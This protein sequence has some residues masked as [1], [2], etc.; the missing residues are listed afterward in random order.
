LIRQFVPSYQGLNDQA[1]RFS[2]E[3]AAEIL[4]NHFS[5]IEVRRYE[6][7]LEV[8][9]AEPLIA[10]VLSMWDAFEE[11]NPDHSQAFASFVQDYFARHERFHIT[12]S[13]GLVIASRMR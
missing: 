2:L 11:R 12:K 9:Q 1:R 13:Q 6:E 8:T 5:Y 7:N 4:S 10:Y 3:N